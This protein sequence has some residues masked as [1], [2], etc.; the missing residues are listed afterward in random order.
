MQVPRGPQKT[1]S[2]LELDSQVLVSLLMGQE[3]RKGPQQEQ[4]VLIAAEPS[5][6]TLDILILV[7]G[8][9]FPYK[10]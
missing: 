3:T 10:K 4:P 9:M 7:F 6:Q 5:L 2:S 1:V 8:S